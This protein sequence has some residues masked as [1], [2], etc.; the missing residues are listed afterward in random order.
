MRYRFPRLKSDDA[1]EC[2][3]RDYFR[4]THG[5]DFQLYGRN[6]QKQYGVDVVNPSRTLQVQAKNYALKKKDIA[7]ILDAHKMK[8]CQAFYI[9]CSGDR[10]AKLQD[11][12][13]SL[14]KSSSLS[15][16][17]LIHILF[18]DDFEELLSNNEDIRRKC[19]QSFVNET[20]VDEFKNLVREHRITAI[21]RDADPALKVFKMNDALDMELFCEDL[22]QLW[23]SEDNHPDKNVSDEIK[24]F[25]KLIEEYHLYL[26]K[27]FFSS[28][29]DICKL[30]NCYGSDFKQFEQNTLNY[31]QNIAKC[32]Y[33]ITK[34]YLNLTDF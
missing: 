19:Y 29:G 1:F 7:E 23:T 22:K 8:G 27:Y 11:Y 6:G 20:F 33:E 28:D 25:L 12:V 21:I 26:S 30:F 32:Y 18:W 2:L 14:S 3:V 34:D 10:D 5:E 15:S 16:S 31:R 9:A 13:S 17:F 24:S 4:V